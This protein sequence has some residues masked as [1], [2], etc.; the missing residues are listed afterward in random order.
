[1][2]K[3]ED[4][5][6]NESHRLGCECFELGFRFQ[7][8]EN[9]N[10]RRALELRREIILDELERRDRVAKST[11]WKLATVK[12]IGEVI[13]LVLMVAVCYLFPWHWIAWFMAGCVLCAV[14]FGVTRAIFSWWKDRKNVGKS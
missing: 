10:Y 8:S 11:D 5:Q 9:G 13:G 14:A 7:A 1:M 2:R 3:F 4:V 6:K 12:L